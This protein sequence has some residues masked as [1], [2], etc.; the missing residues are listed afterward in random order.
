MIGRSQL[1]AWSRGHER[2]QH[3]YTSTHEWAG[4]SFLT[5]RHWRQPIELKSQ[6]NVLQWKN[7]IVPDSEALGHGASTRM[8]LI[9]ESESVVF[10][11]RLK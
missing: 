7:Y 9:A 5:T 1:T 2:A 3:D 8:S 11:C 6:Y 4:P 10:S